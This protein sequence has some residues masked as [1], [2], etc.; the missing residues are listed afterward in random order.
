MIWYGQ[1]SSLGNC[2]DTGKAAR[3]V[4]LRAKDKSE[5]ATGSPSLG[6]LL[7]LQNH[8]PTLLVILEKVDIVDDEHEGFAAL[9][10]ST[11][12]HLFQLV[13]S[14]QPSAIQIAS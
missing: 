2:Q 3:I 6:L 13:E 9:L 14:C 11:Q 12:R 5:N 4:D 8:I 7:Q 1:T 10:C